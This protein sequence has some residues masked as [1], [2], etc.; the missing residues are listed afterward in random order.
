VGDFEYIA[1][2][3]SRAATVFGLNSCY[4]YW[5]AAL[6]RNSVVSI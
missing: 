4:L 2:E 3:S 5:R 1:E 6:G